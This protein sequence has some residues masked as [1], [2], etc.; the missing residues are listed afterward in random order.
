MN[1]KI[2]SM[3][4]ILLGISLTVYGIYASC[5]V[6]QNQSDTSSKIQQTATIRDISLGMRTVGTNPQ[7]KSLEEWPEPDSSWF[8]VNLRMVKQDNGG[9]DIE[10]LRPQE[11]LDAQNVRPGSLI[12]MNMP[13]MGAV[14]EAEVLSVVSAPPIQP[15]EGNVVS[16]KYIHQAANC[17]DLHIEGH[18]KPIGCTDNH[19][20]WSEDRQEFIPVGELH[21]GERILLYS[22][23]IARIAQKLPRPGPETVY[24]LEIWGEH[25]YHVGEFGVLVHNSCAQHTPDQAALIQLAKEAKRNGVTSPEAQI[26]LD[27][28]KEYNVPARGPEV[29]PTRNYNSPHIHVGSVDHIPV[30]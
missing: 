9:L 17:I 21:D 15:G 14:G 12:S 25:V 7:G 1:S 30:R 3:L 23:E 28:A 20:F 10:L 5:I 29:H 16:G 26:F 13:E 27:W 6:P 24:N 4:L 18:D 2:F 22:G 8:Q 11:W 19:P